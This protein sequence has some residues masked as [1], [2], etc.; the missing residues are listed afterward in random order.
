MIDEFGIKAVI[1]FCM[2]NAYKYRWRAGLKEG[3][4]KEQDLAKAQWYI[5]KAEELLS[6]MN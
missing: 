3:N 2:C 4:S 1:D 5:K 6:E